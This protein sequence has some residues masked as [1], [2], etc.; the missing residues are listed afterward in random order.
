MEDFSTP[1]RF[2]RNDVCRKTSNFKLQTL[3]KNKIKEKSVK[4]VISTGAK[5][6]GEIFFE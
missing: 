6:N 5:R 1:L 4:I 2:A 3:L